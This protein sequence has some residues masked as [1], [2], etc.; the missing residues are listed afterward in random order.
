[1]YTEPA[2][3]ALFPVKVVKAEVKGKRVGEPCWDI[4]ESGILCRC[5]S[6]LFGIN[7]GE[8]MSVW[9]VEKLEGA[10]TFAV[11]RYQS[12]IT[13]TIWPAFNTTATTAIA[14]TIAISPVSSRD[15]RV[16]ALFN[17]TTCPSLGRN[18][19]DFYLRAIVAEDA[20]SKIDTAL[21]TNR[22]Y[23]K[24]LLASGSGL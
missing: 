10:V 17:E 18:A 24:T 21:C 9:D 13:R 23:H 11:A 1:M 19:Y 16:P 4:E 8:Y 6:S 22:P 14:A 5:P 7:T 3:H 15:V 2:Q 20:A 12:G